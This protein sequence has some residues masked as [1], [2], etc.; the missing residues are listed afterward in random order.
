M[1]GN[2]IFD[3]VIPMPLVIGIGA[4]MSGLVIAYYFV[5]AKG[6]GRFRRLLLAFIRLCALFVMILILARP[7]IQKPQEETS[8]K[9]VICI[10]ADSSESMNTKD[11]NNKSRYETM[12][13]T[14]CGDK[15]NILK[16]LQN[17]YDLRFYSFDKDIRRI[18]QQQFASSGKADVS[19]ETADLSIL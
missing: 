7:M 3:P 18:S 9:P 12:M 16:N 11:I 13:K 19:K 14:L 6:T 8:Q 4:V 17:N 2:I 5:G 1:F 10:M 15:D